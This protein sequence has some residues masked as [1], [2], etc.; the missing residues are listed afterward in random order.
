[1]APPQKARGPLAPL[2]LCSESPETQP[3]LTCPGLGVTRV[4]GLPWE[5]HA[6][7]KLYGTSLVIEMSG[8]P[9]LDPFLTQL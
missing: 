4:P 3:L 1:M 6:T 7:H 8:G 5:L 9:H 2:P